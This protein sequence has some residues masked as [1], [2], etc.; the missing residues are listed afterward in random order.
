MQ[1]SN[2]LLEIK[3]FKPWNI[4]LLEFKLLLC[5]ISVNRNI[6]KWF[7]ILTLKIK[8]YTLY[9]ENDHILLTMLRVGI[10]LKN[11]SKNTRCQLYSGLKLSDNIFNINNITNSQQTQIVK[12]S[13]PGRFLAISPFTILPKS[14]SFWHDTSHI[15]CVCYWISL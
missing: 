3:R 9:R 12:K 6:F 7:E 15:S 1:M 8:S 2:F 14:V 5:M 13:P 10:T 11:V 4:I